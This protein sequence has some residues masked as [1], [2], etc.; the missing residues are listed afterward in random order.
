M[1]PAFA[2]DV[3]F[4]KLVSGR[5]DV[6]LIE[7]MLEFAADAYPDVDRCRQLLEIDRLGELARRR[8]AEL[9]AERRSL[10]ERLQTISRLLYAEERFQGNE[11]A[12]YDPRNSY[13]NEVLAR[14]T[15]IPIS[16]AIVYMAVAARAG[17]HTFGVAAPGHF[18]V[19]ARE[20]R[21]SWFV[22]PFHL[23]LVLD[24]DECRRRI[25]QVLGEP[26]VIGDGHFRPASAREIGARVLRNLKAAY[27]MDNQWAPALP[28][29]QRLVLL[30]PEALDEGRDLGLMY[31]RNGR[32]MQAL[33][34]LK[35]YLENC[36]EEQAQAVEPYLRAARRLAAEMN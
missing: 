15:G 2:S 14:R 6:D 33:T 29:Q 5:N 13:L 21:E 22:D 11:E 4:N 34:L 3:E 35:E 23:G 20:A 12:Y 1:P 17:V 7:L 30:L 28:V 27:V 19:G 26:G 18:V 31:L 9:D 36:S 32:P 16:L 10:E 8:I 25:E 24:R